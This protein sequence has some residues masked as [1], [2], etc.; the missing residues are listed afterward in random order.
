MAQTQHVTAPAAF[1]RSGMLA[2]L[3]TKLRDWRERRRLVAELDEMAATGELEPLLADAGLS[4][5]QIP[6][7]LKS[8]SGA[9]RLLEAMAARL[10]VD[11]DAMP[12]TLRRDV[13]WTCASC[14]EQR[15]CRR[16]LARSRTAGYAAFCPNTPAFRRQ[17]RAAANT[18]CAIT[19]V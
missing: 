9:R 10:G 7:L 5:A 14:G 12:A 4:R 13:E 18:E 17:L 3:A 8:A 1:A 11:L 6:T 19:G 15:Q 2:S 16:W